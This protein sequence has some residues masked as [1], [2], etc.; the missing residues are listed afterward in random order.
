MIDRT[1][2]LP[3]TRQAQALGIA[4]STV[5]ARPRPVSDRD[6]ELMKGIDGLQLEMPFAG[7]PSAAWVD[8]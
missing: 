3:I 2:L 4:R 7:C 5:Y 8:D 6:L 1:H